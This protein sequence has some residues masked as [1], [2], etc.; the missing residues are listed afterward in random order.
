MI[1]TKQIYKTHN[2]KLL[3]IV[4]TFKQW[5]HYLENSSHIIKMWSN[6]NNLKEFMKQKK[7]NARQ[8]R[9]ALKLIIYD[10]EIYH[11]ASKNNSA[12]DSSRR[13]DYEKV[14]I[15]NIKLLST[16]QNKL[17]LTT[18]KLSTNKRKSTKSNS[19]IIIDVVN[20]I[21][22]RYTLSQSRQKLTI[23]LSLVF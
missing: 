21:D 22:K 7:L 18:A 2:Q 9:W 10:F 15:L 12:N 5:R 23:K 6:H 14:S 17:L 20:V 4:T 19:L 3:V 11:R 8:T 16:L 13:L 1:S